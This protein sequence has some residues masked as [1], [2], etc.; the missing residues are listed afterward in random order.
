MHTECAICRQHYMLTVATSN[1]EINFHYHII[2]ILYLNCISV[3]LKKK[4]N[5]VWGSTGSELASKTP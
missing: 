4:K 2:Q 1:I 3:D 5:R